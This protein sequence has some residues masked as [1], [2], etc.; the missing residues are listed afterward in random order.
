[1]QRLNLYDRQKLAF[2][3]ERRVSRRA[4]ARLMGR[5]HSVILRELSRNKGD[6]L[7]Y[8]PDHAQYFAES[9]AR[10]K[11]KTKFEKYPALK[12][13][14]SKNIKE[15]LSPEQVSA[16][17]KIDPPPELL[18][19]TL[20]TESI[21]TF[22]YASPLM[23]GLHAHLRRKR[24]KRRNRHGRVKQAKTLLKERISIHAR[25]EEINQR[26]EFGH[27]ESDSMVFSKQHEGLSVQY[28]RS[29]QL[30]RI[31]KIANRSAQETED[32]LRNSIESLPVGSFKTLTFDNGGEGAHHM[33]IRD[34]FEIDTF[35]CD[36]Y[37]SWQKGGV[38]NVNGLIRQYL[39]RK[40]DLSK[41]S[42]RDI[43]LIQERLN[44]RPRKGLGYKTPNQKLQAYLE[45]VH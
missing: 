25:P 12:E 14:V 28:E 35:F 29:L 39:P 36:P 2:W 5:D 17:L 1:M 33:I 11:K 41:V 38:E 45:M 34:E 27:W 18:G 21:Y 24:L 3:C 9:R 23:D 40:A 8:N 16:M 13:Y 6:Y 22:V 43:Y 30:V 19:I 32:A 10:K 4:L 7:P 15:G 20:C 44:N 31:N 37:A 26:K 42:H